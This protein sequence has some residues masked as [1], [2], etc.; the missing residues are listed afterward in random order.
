[1]IEYL[2]E[3][4]GNSVRQFLGGFGIV[5][6][7]A[8]L[9]WLL[10]QRRRGVACGWLGKAYYYLVAP[11]V[12]FHE[13]GHALGCVITLTKISKMVLFHPQGDTLG[14]V[15]HV[16]PTRFSALR[17]FVIAT[18]PVWLGC[19][20]I[21]LLGYFTGGTGFM[22]DYSKTF[23]AGEPG[24]MEYVSATFAA[25][26][27]MFKSLIADWKWTSPLHLLLLYLLFC[28]TSEIT[29]SPP[30]ISGMWGGI[31]GIVLM[32]LL[33]NLIPGLSD[34]AAATAKWFAPYMFVTHASLLFV[35]LIDAA[36]YV[37]FKL[38]MAVF[39]R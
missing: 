19:A 5:F 34:A 27:G 1:M 24:F 37:V 10:S 14:Y 32:V 22:P 33:F 38:I 26:F 12:M 28:V 16:Q 4:I 25:A 21:V 8:Y 9:M 7:L 36:F 13:L 15:E 18:G 2:T 17:E 29:L 30:D 3:A 6:L 31:V 20:A 23:P 35:L 39:R 11:G